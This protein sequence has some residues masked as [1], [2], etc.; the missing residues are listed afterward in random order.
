MLGSNSTRVND[1]RVA[2][3]L[4]QVLGYVLRALGKLQVSSVRVDQSFRYSG[5]I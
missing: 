3:A 4:Y 2:R 1:G 5:Y